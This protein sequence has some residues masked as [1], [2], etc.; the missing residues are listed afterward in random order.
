MYAPR[1]RRRCCPKRGSRFCNRMRNGAVAPFAQR[2]GR[3]RARAATYSRTLI[4]L[5]F[6]ASACITQNAWMTQ[7]RVLR[8][9]QNVAVGVSSARM[10]S[11]P[12]QAPSQRRS[13]PLLR[14]ARIASIEWVLKRRR[15]GSGCIA[16]YG[17]RGF[18]LLSSKH[19]RCVFRF[20]SAM[21]PSSSVEISQLHQPHLGRMALPKG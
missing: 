19:A 12:G 17:R 20:H 21:I 5:N 1:A 9:R 6:I 4:P 3:Q 18:R 2:V 13:A 10:S 15:L 14:A 16:D 11:G 8:S 7:L